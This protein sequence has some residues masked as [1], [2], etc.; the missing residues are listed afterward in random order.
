M[1]DHV[2]RSTGLVGTVSIQHLTFNSPS[3]LASR[4]LKMF[5]SHLYVCKWHRYG[6]DT[7]DYLW[8]FLLFLFFFKKINSVMCSLL[9]DTI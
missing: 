4:L 7:Q 2:L 8:L 6:S 5:P 9:Y 3:Q 1:K